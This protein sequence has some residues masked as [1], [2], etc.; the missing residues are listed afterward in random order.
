MKAPKRLSDVQ[1]DVFVSHLSMGQEVISRWE[2]NFADQGNTWKI[3]RSFPMKFSWIAFLLSLG[4]PDISN[5]TICRART[6]PA[7]LLPKRPNMFVWL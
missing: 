5:R 7:F 3:V 2:E 6:E 1:R 4:F